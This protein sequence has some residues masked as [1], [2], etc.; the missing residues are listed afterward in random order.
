MTQD[1]YITVF[2]LFIAILTVILTGRDMHCTMLIFF[3]FKSVLK[4]E[5][6]QK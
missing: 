5:F 3:L 6:T 2:G 4:R 1:K